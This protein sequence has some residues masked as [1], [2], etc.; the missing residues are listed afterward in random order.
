MIWLPILLTAFLILI[1][2]LARPPVARRKLR[3]N[4][5]DRTAEWR[6]VRMVERNRA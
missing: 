2:I 5:V 6:A 3:R 1:D 4:T